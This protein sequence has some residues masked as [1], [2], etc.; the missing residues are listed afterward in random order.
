[1]SLSLNTGEFEIQINLLKIWDR[2][3]LPHVI[4][5]FQIITEDMMFTNKT[6]RRRTTLR[7]K[8]SISL[9]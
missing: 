8:R 5:Q 4:S 2:R 6:L 1:M 7:I 3:K 9:V